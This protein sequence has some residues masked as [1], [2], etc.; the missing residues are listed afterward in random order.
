M[1]KSLW[2]RY[3]QNVSL[4]NAYSTADFLKQLAL[5]PKDYYFGRGR[6]SFPLNIN[7]A[8]TLRCNAACSMCALSELLNSTNNKELS[9]PEYK[10]F[11]NHCSRF[12]PGFVLYGG[13]PF[14]RKDIFEIIAEIKGHK[15]SCGAF[16]NGQLLDKHML[17]ELIKLK[18]NF[19]VFS[20]YGPSQV[21]DRIVGIKGAYEK[22]IQNAAYLKKHR[23]N[24]KVIIHCT[25]S[26]QNIGHL[27]EICR[28]SVCDNVR[29]GHLT[30]IPQQ[31]KERAVSGLKAAFPEE[32]I[33]FKTHI[34][35]P[36]PQKIHEFVEN[37]SRLR[38]DAKLFFTPELSNKEIPDWYNHEFR[39]QRRCLF[40]WRGVFIAP[41]GDVYPCM[42]NFYYK[43]GNILEDNLGKIWNN[44][45]F[46]GLR[47]NL[48]K[49][50]LTACAR[51]CR[52]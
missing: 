21:H 45:K 18:M 29:F 11:I 47:R 22:I 50:L 23:K 4:L 25:V 40:I 33:P 5:F 48:K 10:N 46:V 14:L 15:L 35:D 17:D 13:E 44:E 8:L 2:R 28:L 26:D 30:F 7:L 31:L 51:C 36:Q 6:S 9:L 3:Y 16:T 38:K 42:G 43:M 20:L 1:L 12:R 39:T 37:L 24:T 52:L 41:N 34:Y 27:D 32:E 49:G 19:M